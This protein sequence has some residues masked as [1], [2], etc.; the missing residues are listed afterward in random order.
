MLNATRENFSLRDLAE[1]DWAKNHVF[2]NVARIDSD[3]I[4]AE[5]GVHLFLQARHVFS[6]LAA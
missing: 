6:F 1:T 4:L 5:N 3:Q 2:P